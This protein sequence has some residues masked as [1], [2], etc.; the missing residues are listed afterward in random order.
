MFESMSK[1]DFLLK[2]INVSEDWFGNGDKMAGD[3]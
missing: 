2:D 1:F 3:M